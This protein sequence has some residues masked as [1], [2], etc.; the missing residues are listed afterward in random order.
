[1]EQW[2]QVMR[3]AFEGIGPSQRVREAVKADRDP[4]GHRG[5]RY[6]RRGSAALIAALIAVMLCGGTA[7]VYQGAAGDIRGILSAI[8]QK[9]SGSAVPEEQAAYLDR[10]SQEIGVSRTVDGVTLTV[11]SATVGE[12]VLYLLLVME[13]MEWPEWALDPE[14]ARAMDFSVTDLELTA[15]PGV[16]LEGWSACSSIRKE[17]DGAGRLMILWRY[18]WEG[19]PAPEA[20]DLLPVSIRLDDLV[21]QRIVDGVPV[22]EVEVA[23]G[24][25]QLDFTVETPE[26]EAPL[27][28]P[29]TELVL[30]DRAGEAL[31]VSMN[32]L[33]VTGTGIAVEIESS[34][35][36][37]ERYMDALMEGAP[38]KL[39]PDC[40][41]SLFG[42]MSPT[43]ILRDGTEIGS[44][45]ELGGGASF[46]WTEDGM[47]LEYRDLWLVP[48]DPEQV[49]SVRIGLTTVPLDR[50]REE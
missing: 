2:S 26:V 7:A 39:H 40:Q 20:G 8:W 41:Q 18:Y 22:E 6:V 36:E 1:M 50:G 47:G 15:L 44:G 38:E 32:G 13:G 46:Q 19:A 24:I 5:S 12:N 43:L 21:V 3:R 45:W 9:S 27:R 35:E 42:L 23:E 25:W 33:E 49:E 31:T 30:C 37:L 14:Q 17:L 4:A 48:V 34:R 11:D 16:G 28:G 29:D 10:L